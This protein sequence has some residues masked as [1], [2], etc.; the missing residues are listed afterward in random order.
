MPDRLAV[1][2]IEGHE[3]TGITGE[4]QA[5]CSGQDSAAQT[6]AAARAAAAMLM[7]PTDRTRPD[8]HRHQ[9][10]PRIEVAAATTAVS[11]RFLRGVV[12]IGDAVPLSA[13]EIEELRLRV[14]ARWWPIGGAHCR[15]IDHRTVHSG[16]FSG[17]RNRLPFR[18]NTERPVPCACERL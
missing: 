12:Q 1:G 4:E 10:R 8:V 3:F 15:H 18:V 11:L 5:A 17:V 16:F 6:T 14:V 13:V 9:C 7:L 2:G